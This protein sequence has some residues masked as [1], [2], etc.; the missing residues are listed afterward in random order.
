MIVRR[1]RY[2][3]HEW[4]E[5]GRRVLADYLCAGDNG[6]EK[7]LRRVKIIILTL[8]KE[9]RIEFGDGGVNVEV[10]YGKRE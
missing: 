10:C 7:N 1:G 8:E 5:N 6:Y 3:R 9:V 2:G 4:S